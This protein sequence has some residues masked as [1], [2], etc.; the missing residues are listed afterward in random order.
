[1]PAQYAKERKNRRKFNVPSLLFLLKSIELSL[2]KQ[3]KIINLKI[4]LKRGSP[5]LDDYVYISYA[6]I[7]K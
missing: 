3:H 4:F 7:Y 1:M 2:S 6:R 5:S